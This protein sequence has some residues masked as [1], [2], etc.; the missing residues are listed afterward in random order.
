L[1]KQPPRP[2]EKKKDGHKE[3]DWQAT[4][5]SYGFVGP[6]TGLTLLLRRYVTVLPSTWVT[7]LLLAQAA[8]RVAA[9][10]VA[11]LVVVVVVVV[12]VSYS[13]VVVM[14]MVV[15]RVIVELA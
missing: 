8:R 6:G 12:V 2:K 1:K 3:V 14:V 4:Q 13:E 10:I 9:G 11:V 7:R 15:L 5:Q